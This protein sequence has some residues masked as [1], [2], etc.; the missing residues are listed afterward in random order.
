MDI[1][2]EREE[3]YHTEIHKQQINRKGENNQKS[4][5]GGVFDSLLNPNKIT[6]NESIM[7]ESH[8]KK[9]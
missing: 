1:N 9:E 3:K 4:S 7:E 6:E 8:V 5:L 2:S